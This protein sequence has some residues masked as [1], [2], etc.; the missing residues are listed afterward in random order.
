MSPNPDQKTG[1]G[2]SVSENVKEY[3]LAQMDNRVD[4]NKNEKTKQLNISTLQ[5]TIMSVTKKWF[6]NV[7]NFELGWGRESSNHSDDGITYKCNYLM[8]K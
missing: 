3:I 1:L 2:I 4:L 6:R 7:K 8:S 5:V